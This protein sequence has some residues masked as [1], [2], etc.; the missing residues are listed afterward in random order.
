MC[1]SERPT[2]LFLTGARNLVVAL[3]KE[4][5][6]KDPPHRPDLPL[7]ESRTQRNPE[8][9]TSLRPDKNHQD[10][11]QDDNYLFSKSDLFKTTVTSE[12]TVICI[13]FLYS[14]SNLKKLSSIF[15]YFET[16]Q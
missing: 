12:V 1:H 7:Y 4:L 6:T 9:G 14:P 10:F 11:V 13:I 3:G 2:V 8:S 5:K 15:N 16:T